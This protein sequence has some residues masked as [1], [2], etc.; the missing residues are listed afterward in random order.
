MAEHWTEVL[1]GVG[2]REHGNSEH[3]TDGMIY[4]TLLYGL[5]DSNVTS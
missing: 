3:G 1:L 2:G 5:I 4:E